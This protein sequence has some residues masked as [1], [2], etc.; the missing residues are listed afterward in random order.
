MN[1]DSI[2]DPGVEVRGEPPSVRRTEIRGRR[3]RAHWSHI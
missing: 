2:H 3:R 1:D